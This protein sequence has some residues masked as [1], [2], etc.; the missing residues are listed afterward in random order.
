MIQILRHFYIVYSL[1]FLLSIWLFW[2]FGTFVGLF[3][4]EVDLFLLFLFSFAPMNRYSKCSTLKE[5]V[6]KRGEVPKMEICMYTSVNFLNF[7]HLCVGKSYKIFTNITMCGWIE[8]KIWCTENDDH[9]WKRW[10]RMTH[11]RP[12]CDFW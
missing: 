11:L 1:T 10:V 9:L 3:L 8:L 12:G 5:E 6:P 2:K 7:V 4:E